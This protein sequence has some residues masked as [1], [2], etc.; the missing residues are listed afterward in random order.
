MGYISGTVK[1][2][3]LFSKKKKKAIKGL[4]S[5]GQIGDRQDLKIAPD[6]AGYSVGNNID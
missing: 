6:D 2:V 5:P 3:L 1:D 4:D